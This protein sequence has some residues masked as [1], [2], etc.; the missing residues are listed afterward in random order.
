MN[1]IFED[2]SPAPLRVGLVAC[3]ASKQPHAAP[4]ADLYT[5]DL[6]CK[7][8]RLARLRCER[9]YILSALHGLLDPARVIEPYDLTLNDMP[10]HLRD[11]WSHRVARELQ[12]ELGHNFQPIELT[13]LAGRHYVETLLP[14]LFR[15]YGHWL[16]IQ[17]PLQ[18]LGIGQQ[19]ARLVQ[20][21]RGEVAHG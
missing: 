5:S 20:L 8:M 9:V 3:A 21:L 10:K 15:R 16:T 4:A 7:S 12:H 17:R 11:A 1:A 2:P 18:G 14:E 13:V 19:K 6:F